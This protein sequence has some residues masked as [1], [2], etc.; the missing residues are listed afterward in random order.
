MKR[1]WRTLINQKQLRRKELPINVDPNRF[2]ERDYKG[3]P[4][5]MRP[6]EEII[7]AIPIKNA[8]RHTFVDGAIL[9][10]L[11]R[12][13]D[14]PFEEFVSKVDICKAVTYMNDYIGGRTVQV[15]SDSK[16]RCIH[17]LERTV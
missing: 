9:Y 5:H 14:F 15:K 7:G 12:D 1:L 11:E 10:Y 16:G 13:V 8:S 17:Q 6:L 2:K 4:A 3:L